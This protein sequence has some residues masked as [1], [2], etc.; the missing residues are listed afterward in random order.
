MLSWS[1][2]SE[3][4]EEREAEMSERDLPSRGIGKDGL[5]ARA[6]V[7]RIQEEGNGDEQDEDDAARYCRDGDPQPTPVHH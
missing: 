4:R 1:A 6:V 7:V 5:N 3:P 2:V